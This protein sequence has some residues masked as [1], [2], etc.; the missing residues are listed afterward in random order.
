MIVYLD[1]NVYIEAD[2]VF[3][4]DE[5]MTLR[6][7]IQSGKLEVL[8]TI[9]TAGR[10][11]EQIETDIRRSVSQYNRSLRKN[12]GAFRKKSEY[13][14]R[15]IPPEKAVE[16]IHAGFRR[17]LSMDGVTRIPLDPVSADKLISDYYGGQPPFENKKDMG[18]QDAIVINALRQYAKATDL[19]CVVSSDKEFRKAFEHDKNFLPFKNLDS[20][21]RFFQQTQ[22]ELESLEEKIN[23]IIAKGQ[24]NEGIEQYIRDLDII[25]ECD[26]DCLCRNAEVEDVDCYLAYI[27]EQD[28]KLYAIIDTMLYIS[29]DVVYID[30]DRSFYDE[31]RRSYLVENYRTVKERHQVPRKV[32]AICLTN[33]P[34]S[35]GRRTLRGYKII[36]DKINTAIDLTD[37]TMYESRPAEEE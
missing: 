8:Y 7:L 18:F 2:Y 29:A 31:K 5:F 10:V 34:D 4:R 16:E 3:D 26:D 36:H 27:E 14:L 13:S 21:L 28:D 35:K 20:F 30:K 37:E 33:D 23:E 24:M 12:M 32:K 11:N 15:E 1:S 9:A 17:F 22:P 19:V 6:D 25:R